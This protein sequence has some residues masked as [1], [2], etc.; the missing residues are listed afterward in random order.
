[1]EAL[2]HQ[3]DSQHHMSDAEVRKMAI[4]AAVYFGG[5]YERAG[6]LV[7]NSRYVPGLFSKSLFNRH[8]YAVRDL[9][10]MVFRVLGE[11]FN[12]LNASSLYIIDRLPAAACVNIRIARDKRFNSEKFCVYTTSK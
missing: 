3:A 5:H 6:L 9:L 1:M 2:K 10:L 4:V 8:I 7:A 12:P 11:M